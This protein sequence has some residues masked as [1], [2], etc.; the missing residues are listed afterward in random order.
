MATNEKKNTQQPY[1][2]SC[3]WAAEVWNQ[4]KIARRIKSAIVAEYVCAEKSSFVIYIDQINP[5]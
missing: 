3:A 5:K 4:E 2:R 1:V